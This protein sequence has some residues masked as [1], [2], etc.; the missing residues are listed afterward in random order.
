[1]LAT[2]LNLGGLRFRN[3]QYQFKTAPNPITV[4]LHLKGGG[5]SSSFTHGGTVFMRDF[6]QSSGE[7]FLGWDGTG[8]PNNSTGG[9]I[10]GI[11]VWAGEGTTGGRAIRLYATSDTARPGYMEFRNL[12][13]AGYVNGTWTYAFEIDGANCTTSGSQGLRDTH[14]SNVWLSGATSVTCLFGNATQTTLDGLNI[15]TG[16]GSVASLNISG[17]S[18]ASTAKSQGVNGRVWVAGDLIFNACNACSIVGRA[19][20]VTMGA[21]ATDSIFTGVVDGTV[22]VNAAS[23]SKVITP[24]REYLPAGQTN[25]TT[26]TRLPGNMILAKGQITLTSSTASYSFGVTFGAVPGVTVTVENAS[27][28]YAFKTAVTTTGFNAAANVAGPV[29]ADWVAFGPAP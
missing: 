19:T 15:V 8:D 4:G 7:I 16:T 26:Y 29:T 18:A 5:H 9:G 12:L 2:Q 24:S 14:M 23:T 21:D 6:S 10:D 17:L 1:V 3:G 13:V 25:E 11:S 28:A 22:T 20:N 27:A